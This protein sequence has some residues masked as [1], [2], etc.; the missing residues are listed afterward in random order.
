MIRFNH[1]RLLVAATL[2][3]AVSTFSA[4]TASAQSPEIVRVRGEIVSLEG[5]ALTVK[6]RQGANVTIH[7]AD[8]LRVVGIVR[9]SIA[10]I[11]PGVFIG[12]SSV[13]KEGSTSR[14]LEIHI[15]PEASRG[16]GEGDRPWDLMPGSSM[17]NGTAATA[18]D[19]ADGKTVTITYKGGQRVIVI[20]PDT[21]IV[22]Y[23]AADKSDLKPGAKVFITTQKGPDGTLNARS[24]SV[25]KDGIT[26]P[27]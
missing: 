3:G 1:A 20:Q 10:D 21:A 15:L 2:I 26:P 13:P 4:S 9:A 8:D 18:V 5:A 22:T 14:A 24:V 12:T 16:A 19:S 11:K 6:S 23:M 27:M 7:L 25:G 17:T